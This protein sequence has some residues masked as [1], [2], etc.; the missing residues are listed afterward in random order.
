LFASC[1]DFTCYCSFYYF[2]SYF[3]D[4]GRGEGYSHTFSFHEEE[5]YDHTLAKTL[6]NLVPLLREVGDYVPL[7]TFLG[8]YVIHPPVASDLSRK[9][10]DRFGGTGSSYA[11]SRGLGFETSPIKTRSVRRKATLSHVLSDAATTTR[12]D[13]GVLR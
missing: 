2:V 6:D 8:N 3:N 10:W 13:T 7:D 5:L 11:W 9:P 4:K 12:S 1:D